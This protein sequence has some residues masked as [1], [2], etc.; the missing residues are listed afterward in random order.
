MCRCNQAVL[1]GRKRTAA[2]LFVTVVLYTLIFSMK[3]IH[4]LKRTA[5]VL[6]FK[7]ELPIGNE[8]LKRTTRGDGGSLPARAEQGLTTAHADPPG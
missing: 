3:T 4:Y 6:F 2:V 1:F 5:G 8:L 7:K